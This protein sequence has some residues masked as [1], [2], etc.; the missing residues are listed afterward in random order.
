MTGEDDP[1]RP[2]RRLHI[3]G[4][5][6]REGWEILNI[7]PGPGVDHVADAADLSEFADATFAELYASHVLEHLDYRDKVLAA[8]TEWRRVLHPG[9]RLY[10]GVPDL[11]AV[12]RL[13]SAERVDPNDQMLLVRVIFGGHMDP[14]DYHQTAFTQDILVGFLTEAG[15]TRL[16]R[17]RSFGLFEDTSLLAFKGTALSINIVAEKP[18]P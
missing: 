4:R 18:G 10:V 16:R 17:V 6:T 5:A 13:L 12:A 15:Y 8:L 1:D 11:G 9:G 7:Q 2:V 14:Y 3:G